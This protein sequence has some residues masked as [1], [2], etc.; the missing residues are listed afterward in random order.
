MSKK[1]QKDGVA[2]DFLF[3]HSKQIFLCV[4][5]KAVCATLAEIQNF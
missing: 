2:M 5:L 4:P 3:V 1:E